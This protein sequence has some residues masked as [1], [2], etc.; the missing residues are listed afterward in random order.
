MLTL[1]TS[2]GKAFAIS[3]F[4]II[5]QLYVFL[6]QELLWAWRRILDKQSDNVYTRFLRTM[7]ENEATTLF[8]NTVLFYILSSFLSG[9]GGII[10][11]VFGWLAYI[12]ITVFLAKVLGWDKKI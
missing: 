11:S 8:I 4:K 9:N 6:N 5:L 2:S 1:D 7:L 10:G 12:N 3:L